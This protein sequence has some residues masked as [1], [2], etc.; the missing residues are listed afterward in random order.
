MVFK[1]EAWFQTEHDNWCN[2]CRII[3]WF[4]SCIGP[5]LYHDA[6]VF[7]LGYKQWSISLTSCH[8]FVQFPLPFG[9]LW[10]WWGSTCQLWHDGESTTSYQLAWDR[11]GTHHSEYHWSLFPEKHIYLCPFIFF[12]V[13]CVEVMWEIYQSESST[14]WPKETFLTYI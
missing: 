7:T 14:V 1:Q 4:P 3:P 12:A 13:E 2:G 11:V 8:C 10:S 6:D 9:Q 5:N